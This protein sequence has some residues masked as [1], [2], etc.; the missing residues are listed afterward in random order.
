MDDH[1]RFQ[2]AE[3]KVAVFEIE[4]LQPRDY[5]MF[6]HEYYQTRAEGIRCFPNMKRPHQR[7]FQQDDQIELMP[8][9][10]GQSAYVLPISKP[11]NV[12]IFK[13]RFVKDNYVSTR[14]DKIEI[15]IDG[16]VKFQKKITMKEVNGKFRIT[17]MPLAV[18]LTFCPGSN[19]DIEIRAICEVEGFK[20]MAE[21]KNWLISNEFFEDEYI[22]Y[23]LAT[24]L[25]PIF[26][27]R[28][29]SIGWP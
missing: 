17:S 1:F 6:N 3:R 9:N 24:F 18:N 20:S 27:S 5:R 11:G 12:D 28:K 15:Q 21:I 29:I 26:S 7:Y 4:L 14:I 10:T 23:V 19:P 13:L 8:L 22:A 25:N 16:E 2:T